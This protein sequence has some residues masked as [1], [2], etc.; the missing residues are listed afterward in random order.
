MAQLRVDLT[1]ELWA[2]RLV[3]RSEYK[4]DALLEQLKAGGMV[5]RLVQTMVVTL[6]GR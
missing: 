5:D 3:P 6:V 2:E 4:T 1:V